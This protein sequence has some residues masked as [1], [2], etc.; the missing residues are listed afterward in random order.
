M[1]CPYCNTNKDRVIDSR[2]SEGGAVIRR[3]RECL[4]CN[5]R[6]TTYERI[7][8][9][10]RLMVV[11]KG[12][13]RDTFDREKIAQGVHAACGKRPI[14]EPDVLSLIDEV[15]DELHRKHDREVASSVIGELVMDKLKKIDNVAFIR[16]AS[17]YYQFKRIEDIVQMIEETAK[18]PRDVKN[19]Q[20]LFKQEPTP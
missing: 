19:Q 7:E 14:P 4:K 6:F 16:F 15:E 2:S 8:K 18:L 9:A 20:P 11:K 10:T 13:T 17:E 1:I 3:R 12:G 5:K